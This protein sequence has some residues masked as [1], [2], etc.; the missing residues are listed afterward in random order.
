MAVESGVLGAGPSALGLAVAQAVHSLTT[1]ASTTAPFVR[2]VTGMLSSLP[3][4]ILRALVLK[5]L[6]P[7][8]DRLCFA[9]A[10]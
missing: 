1:N 4:A 7:A 10:L 8:F 3:V 9:G 6:T 5:L 2:L